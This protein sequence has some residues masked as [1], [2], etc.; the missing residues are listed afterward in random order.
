MSGGTI[1]ASGIPSVGGYVQINPTYQFEIDGDITF[2]NTGSFYLYGGVTSGTGGSFKYTS[3]NVTTTGSSVYIQ[4]MYVDSGNIRWNKLW[5]LSGSLASSVL[6]N[7]VIVDGLLILGFL[8]VSYLINNDGSTR[9]IFANGGISLTG[10]TSIISGTANIKTTSGTITGINTVQLRNNLEIVGDVTFASGVSFYYN[11]GILLYTSGSVITT[12]STL[13]VGASTTINT[14]GMSWNNITMNAISTITL[15]SILNLTGTLT[16]SNSVTFSGNYNINCSNLTVTGGVTLSGD[17]NAS[18]LVTLGS[19]GSILT[20]TSSGGV[21]T[22]VAGNGFTNGTT[23]GYVVCNV[24]IKVTGGTISSNGTL[25]GGYIQINTTYQFEIDGDVIFSSSNNFYIYGGVTSGTGGSFKHTSG[26]VTTTGSGLWIQALYFDSGSI[27]W[28]N[29]WFISGSNNSVTQL[30]NDVVVNGLLILGYAAASYQINSDTSTRT[31]YANNGLTLSQFGTQSVISGTANIKITNGILTTYNNSNQLRLNL[32]FA[33]DVSFNDGEFFYY[34]TGVLSHTSGN[35]TTYNSTLSNNGVSATYQCSGIK[36]YNF[37]AST[38]TLT[39]NEDLNVTNILSLGS[40]S[41]TLIINPSSEQ[42]IY[43]S[44]IFDV[45]QR[46]TN[47]T[48][49]IIS[50]GT[51]EVISGTIQNNGTTNKLCQLKSNLNI[52]S[53]GIVTISGTVIYNTGIFKYIRGK[54]ITKNSTLSVGNSSTFIDCHKI[55]FD[56]VNITSN[57]NINM[58]EFFCG[59]PSLIT[60]VTPSST[61]NYTITFT[62]STE[63]FAK[64]VKVSRATTSINNQLTILTRNSNGGN[65][66]G[67]NFYPNQKPNG[68]AKN[69]PSVTNEQ[70]NSFGGILSDPIFK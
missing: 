29:L 40:T 41:N 39:I 17:I 30:Q 24:N 19:G 4:T 60:Q 48:S 62:D 46:S 10:N 25:A 27:Q 5:F 32:E 7:D 57:A 12:N 13:V 14:S 2:S 42:K 61:T 50:G 54:V 70:T 43:S 55:Q 64:F 35:V 33:G 45:G 66:V 21:R 38:G 53:N 59:S 18:G 65:N 31:I 11:T 34:N 47:N 36:W 52:N 1:T 51:I 3:G 58:N 68:F 67:I 56:R 44:G 49:C 22:I 63:K 6:Q 15:Q 16:I 69:N 9:T 37:S 8:S 20:L 23:T 26:N 28:N